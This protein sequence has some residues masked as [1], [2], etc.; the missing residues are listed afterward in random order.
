[1]NSEAL[2]AQDGHSSVIALAKATM[3]SIGEA[4]G[5]PCI[6]ALPALGHV[7]HYVPPEASVWQMVP[8]SCN[9][10]LPLG[11][12]APPALVPPAAVSAH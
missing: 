7:N 9:T 5:P 1:M 2:L 10:V 6:S 11:R 4:S 12:G 8:H 3:L